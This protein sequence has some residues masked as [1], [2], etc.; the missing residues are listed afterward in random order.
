[1]AGHQTTGAGLAW[2]W[3]LLGH[4]PEVDARLWR[5]V[6]AALGDAPAPAAADLEHL[7]Y[8]GQVLDEAM[9]LYP[10]GWAFTRAPLGDD[11]LAGR[12]I[13][14]GSVIVISSYANQRAPQIWPDPDRFDPDRF[15]PERP[16][17]DAHA[18][19]PF[20]SG[21]HAC[22]GKHLALDHADFVIIA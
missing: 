7:G 9:R 15:A 4:H 2:T 6:D 16:A 10:P 3:Y 13:R 12:R 11:E 18:Y 22:I 1:M 21:P 14:A 5:E 17:P 8:L 19:F 20:G